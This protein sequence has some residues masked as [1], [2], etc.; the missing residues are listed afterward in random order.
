MRGRCGGAWRWCGGC[1]SGH[2]L[3]VLVVLVMVV[4]VVPPHAGDVEAAIMLVAVL[5]V[6]L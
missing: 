1:G 3:V 5:V 2:V 6:L 4:V